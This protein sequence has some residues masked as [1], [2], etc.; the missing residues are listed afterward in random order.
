MH[1]GRRDHALGCADL[2]DATAVKLAR[3][4]LRITGLT[5]R[6]GG[7]TALDNVSFN[8]APGV[9][10]GLIGPNGAGKTTCFN[11]ISGLYR[12]EAGRIELDGLDLVNLPRH[13]IAS[14][15]V[16]RTFQNLALFPSL[17]VLR[18]VMIGGHATSK[19]G[20]LASALQM[21]FV[22]ASERELL[23]RAR[24]L[25]VRFNLDHLRSERVETLP[26]GVQKRVELARAMAGNPRLLILDE[27]AAGLNHEEVGKLADQIQD[28]RDDAGLTILL[29]EHHMGLVMRISDKVVVLDFGRKIA[30]G[31]P[32][33]IRQHPEVIR[34]Y[35]GAEL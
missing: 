8:V 4:M 3:D 7:I 1:L 34:A 21:H 12:S 31:R 18:N 30:D 6:F 20:F 17:S 14:R 16:G 22:A 24:A 28:L 23:D 9:I 2:S 25:L 29:V 32:D 15:G 10:C 33:D 35:L 13:V 27:P 26:F 5:L 11:C 19:G